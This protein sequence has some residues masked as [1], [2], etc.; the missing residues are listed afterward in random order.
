MLGAW[1]TLTCLGGQCR[2]KHCVPCSTAYRAGISTCFLMRDQTQRGP[3]RLRREILGWLVPRWE[4][5]AI[6][7]P[8]VGYSWRKS[9]GQVLRTRFWGGGRRGWNRRLSSLRP[10]WSTAGLFPPAALPQFC[11]RCLP[12]ARLGISP[13]LPFADGFPGS[14]APRQPLALLGLDGD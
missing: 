3:E 10:L 5:S 12:S 14:S 6:P 9:H 7:G 8:Q 4:Q 13:G 11:S 2:A 1:A